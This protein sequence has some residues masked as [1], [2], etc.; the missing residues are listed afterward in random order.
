[1]IFPDLYNLAEARV[2]EDMI[3]DGTVY[4]VSVAI[5]GPTKV[6]TVVDMNQYSIPQRD[7]VGTRA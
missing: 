4:G 5:E 1:M 6:L 3:L 2:Y 7:R